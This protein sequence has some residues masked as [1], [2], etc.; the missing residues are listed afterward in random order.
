[1]GGVG[2]AAA[3]AAITSIPQFLLMFLLLGFLYLAE[4]LHV[5]GG[6]STEI[7]VS[8]IEGERQAL[9]D[10]KAGLND[11]SG[12]LSSW[13]GD[14]CCTWTGVSCNNM[15]GH[16][17]KLDLRNPLVF[18]KYYGSDGFPYS[19]IDWDA[20]R[21]TSL[22]GKISPSLLKLKHL[23]YLDLSINNFQ[24]IHIPKFMGSLEN[25]RYLN[26]SYAV[27]S[28]TIPPHLGNLS[29]LQY[30]D[31]QN[32]DP[33]SYYQTTINNLQ[34][35]S[36]L[37]SLRYLNMN[38][39]RFTGNWIQAVT[40]LPPSLSEL[41][42]SS[43]ELSEI[44]F[45]LPYANFT[46]SLLVLQLSWN[47]FYSSIPPWL[48]NNITSLIVL[49]LSW[50]NFEGPIPDTFAN[51][52]SLQ[53][54]D[55]SH[56]NIG[57]RIPTTL[58]NLCNLKSLDL[59]GCSG[60]NGELTEYVNSLSTCNSNNS[61]ERLDLSYTQLS[62]RIPSSIGDLSSLIELDLSS[63][64]LS[65]PIPTSIGN[66]LSLTKLDL[67]ST[68]L[69]GRIPTSIGDLSSLIELD[70]LSTQLS[71]PIPTSIGNLLSLTKLDLSSTQL[72]GRI[73]SSI[74]DLS[75]LI[76]LHLFS[77]QLSGPI[78]S[79]IGNLSSLTKLDLSST[80]LSG[81]IPSS[82]GDLSSLIELDLS[83][84]QLSGS[85]P[86][87]IGN[88]S[89]LMGL[90][91]FSTQLSSSIPA[92]I[93]N[94]SSLIGLYLFSTQ[95]SGSIPASIGN[96]SSLRTLYLSETQ[97]TGPI[98]IS[99]GRLS[100]LRDLDLS[101][102]QIM[103][104]TIP[105]SIGELSEL[106]YLRISNSSWRGVISE[107][108]FKNVKSLKT[109]DIELEATNKPLIFEVRRDWIP[110]FSL[111]SISMSDVQMGPNFPSWL[112][113]QKNLSTIILTNVG[114]SDTIP[115]SFWKLCARQWID[116]LDLTRNHIRG[117]VP[118]SLEFF[119]A[120]SVD[121]SFN[122]IEG[123]VPLWSNISSLSLGTNLF[124]G[125]IPQNIGEVLGSEVNQLDFSGN[126][127]NGSI[128]SSICELTSL[129][130]LTLS[131]NSLWGELPDCWKNMED[132]QVLDLQ[133]NN[134]SGKIPP[135]IG[136]LSSLTYLLLSSNNFHGKL[137]SSLEKC[138]NLRSLDLGRN[139]FSGNIP[140]WIGRSLSSLQIIRLRSNFF[141][142]KIPSHLCKLSM[143]HFLDLAHNNLSGFIP[144]FLGNLS[145]LE[146]NDTESIATGYTEHMM[147]V[148]KGRELEYSTTLDLVKSIDLSCNN[149][150]G[151]IPD[152]ITTLV[153]L[154]TLNLS[155]NHLTGKIPEKIGDLQNLETLDLS[156]N[157][158]SGEI[159]PSISSLTFLSHLNLSH[160][161]LS[162][163]IPSS[164][165][166]QTISDASMYAGNSGLC[167]WPL[168]INCPGTNISPPPT[169]AKVDGENELNMDG[170]DG[171]D[172]LWFYI[173][174]VMGFIVGFWSVC[175]TLFFKKSWRIAYF[176]FFSLY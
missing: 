5:V 160:N 162:G 144:Q 140:T 159:P 100:S 123:S 44:P 117:R 13:I 60:I 132:L 157:Q 82:I 167:G 138:T 141:T 102:N 112:A 91:L 66:L 34:W 171:M 79:S 114:I 75:S 126:F 16:V 80:Q 85:I 37:S 116:T 173:G 57:D 86:A 59:S 99:I 67:S 58:G 11:T 49:D 164:N 129:S 153:G 23:N 158:L 4:S 40:M 63:T 121:L 61:L 148:T 97:I 71:G 125:Q 68:Q 92:S 120:G 62:G 166:L 136:S 65:G 12:R 14:D 88:L 74:G 47:N 17:N 107:C 64:Q 170:D 95:L 41:H 137:P 115:N 156:I 84:T 35:V 53:N 26:L 1:M 20:A 24:G 15:T 45:S 174:I 142:G 105:E 32:T 9:L 175:I 76:E 163:K 19:D 106:V 8:C 161:N 93:G 118:N 55:I 22:G 29:R 128:P 51:T 103:D 169:Y 81:R 70:L 104:A 21:Y 69:S 131:N 36:G 56:T 54:L 33:F 50:N 3:A 83:S 146:G 154:G 43:C 42:L 73:P 27:F 124:T 150:S 133:N 122:Q 18:Q 2:A 152:G 39:V 134:L 130:I 10:F 119:G 111:E 96:L 139:G 31:L 168:A 30:L 109:L 149:L 87:S 135:S 113:T 108:H 89:S 6:L 28:G 110:T 72:L 155:M 147:V 165:Q 90:Y 172:M 151:K 77:M 38:Y 101:S 48:F 7:T 46:T 143:L 127:L 98:P 52:S 94:L 176:R 145:A 78:P 25:L